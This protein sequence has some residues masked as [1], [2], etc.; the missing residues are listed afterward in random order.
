MVTIQAEENIN[1]VKSD[2]SELIRVSNVFSRINLFSS[3]NRENLTLAQGKLIDMEEWYFNSNLPASSK[4]VT[5]ESILPQEVNNTE[6]I[7]NKFFSIIN[8]KYV[9]H[10]ADKIYID[11]NMVYIPDKGFQGISFLLAENKDIWRLATPIFKKLLKDE[12]IN[13]DNFSE[14][15]L[16]ASL[17]VINISSFGLSKLA[18]NISINSEMAD[19]LM[20]SKKLEKTLA[21]VYSLQFEILEKFVEYVG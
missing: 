17:I 2:I 16:A 9:L 18:S 10:N 3:K 20:N 15:E 14:E 1:K 5:E 7:L 12:I 6:E 11:K 21:Y 19:K 8:M 4:I 13:F